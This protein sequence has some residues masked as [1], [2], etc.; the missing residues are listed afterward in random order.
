MELILAKNSLDDKKNKK[1]TVDDIAS[2]L[3]KNSSKIFYFDESNAHK[4]LLSAVE[5]LEEKG[6][7]VYLKE[8]RFGLD[9][10][11]YMYEMYLLS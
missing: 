6:L 9:E 2:E 7:S 10:S 4:D 1:I 5:E 3:E 11:D 8:V